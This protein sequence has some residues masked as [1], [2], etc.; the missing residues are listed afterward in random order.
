M[1]S[2]CPTDP[3]LTRTVLVMVRIRKYRREF[4][5]VLS[6][7]GSGLTKDR[8]MRLFLMA[9]T[10]ILIIVPAQLYVLYSFAVKIEYSYD[11][12]L[13]HGKD[14]GDIILMPTGGVVQYDRWIQI[15]LGFAVFTFFGLGHDAQEMYRKWLVYIGFSRIFPSLRLS[16]SERRRLKSSMSSQTTSSRSRAYSITKKFSKT[17][18]RSL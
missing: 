9:T 14:W 13:V 11:W 7:S 6:S 1:A 18:L 2:H 16:K 15:G 17:S 4:S 3:L 5:S 12:S 10:L 8:F